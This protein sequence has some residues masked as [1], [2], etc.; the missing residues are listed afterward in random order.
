MSGTSERWAHIRNS[1]GS[2]QWAKWWKAEPSLAIRRRAAKVTG[3][4]FDLIVEKQPSLFLFDARSDN[5]SVLPCVIARAGEEPLKIYPAAL[6]FAPSGDKEREGDG[7]TP[8]GEFRIVEKNAK[9]HF[10]KSLR[11]SYP[12]QRHAEAALKAKLISSNEHDSIVRALRRHETPPQSTALGGDI[13]IHGGGV[14]ANWTLG[15]VALR[16]EDIDELFATLPLRAKV[17]VRPVK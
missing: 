14:G 6:G 8:E 1:D 5:F 13:M 15:C 17:T 7:R 3:K 9:S 2:T 12:E 10:R 16:N 11:L 4:T